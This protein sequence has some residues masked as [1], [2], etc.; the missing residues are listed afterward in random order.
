MSSRRT[1][2]GVG[3]LFPCV[4]LPTRVSSPLRMASL[5]TLSIAGLFSGIGGIEA[6]LREAGHN[7]R[8]L[9]DS[10][11]L[12]ARILQQ[13]FPR[14]VPHADIRKLEGLPEVDLIAAGFPCQDLS[15]AGR[16]VGIMGANSSLVFHI[17]A[18]LER[19]TKKPEWL[20]F[21]NVPFML[22]LDKGQAMRSLIASVESLGYQWAYRV[23]DSRAFGVPH[24]RR[25]VFFLASISKD[26]KAVLFADNH[27]VPAS[28]PTEDAACGFYWTEGNRGLG[29]AVNAVP[30]L[31]GG[32]GLRIPSPPA[33]WIPSEH[34]IVTPD[35][36]DAERLQGFEADWTKPKHMAATST[37]EIKSDARAR[38]RLV[39]NAVTTHAA[40]WIGERLRRPGVPAA[41][42]CVELSADSRLPTAAWGKGGKI[43]KASVTE[44]PV[45]VQSQPLL[46][47]LEFP[48]M[49]LSKR[50]SA[51]IY[52]RL[53]ASTLKTEPRFLKDLA[54]AAGA[55][56]SV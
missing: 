23:V 1:R 25:R 38:W 36:R 47:F 4:V 45:A 10:D 41:T 43:F 22:S 32:S 14:L 34:R 20:L 15:Q 51:G 53:K 49:P 24:R 27:D 39:G 9:C 18:L 29:W 50:A 40:Q 6:G 33:I 48:T 28:E 26:P 3:S 55:V 19:K 46:E 8:F 17:F 11:V 21:E 31:K 2:I 30:P 44:W 52:R 35:I 54:L 13:H 42:P 5:G 37:S 16:S 12:A 7:I 56:P